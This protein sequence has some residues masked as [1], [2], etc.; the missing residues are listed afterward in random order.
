MLL[1]K[2]VKELQA[3]LANQTA[4]GKTVGFVPTMGALHQ[5]HLTLF[6]KCLTQSDVCVGSIFV[7]PTQFN[8][9][10]DLFKYPRTPGKDIEMLSGAGCHVLFM[11]PVEEVY[12]PGHAT[13]DPLDFGYLDQPMEGAHRPGHFQG[14]AQVVRRLLDI[15]QPDTLFMGQKDYQQFAIVQE[16][17]RQLEVRTKLVMCPIVREEDG[18]AM[19]SRN[20]LLSEEQRLLAP[21]IY[22]A[23]QAARKMVHSHFSREIEQ[24][25]LDRLREPGMEPE[26]F[27]I[28][29]GIT[30]RPVDLFED[31]RLAVA[32]TA[33]KVGAVRLI[34]NM[35]LKED[36]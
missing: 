11:P 18:L 22:Q 28:V 33:V 26:Y 15:V 12:P 14:M 21:K 20:M 31:V 29:D 17:L 13:P 19:S 3:Y 6:Q 8:D 7:N 10:T 9:S 24:A 5:G 23:L 16:M 35:I 36:S 34:D 1:F 27:A 25:A 2:K 32:C 4:K 30:L